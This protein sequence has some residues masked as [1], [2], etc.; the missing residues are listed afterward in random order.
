MTLQGYRIEE[1]KEKFYKVIF[2]A[3]I[4]MLPRRMYFFYLNIVSS[5]LHFSA[6]RFR[7]I[8]ER[9]CI[10]EDTQERTKKR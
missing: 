3:T 8:R 4:I 9:S 2:V 7:I 1:V 5:S 6:S 10:Y